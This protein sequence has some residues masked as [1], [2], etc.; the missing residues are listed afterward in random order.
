MKFIKEKKIINKDVKVDLFSVIFSSALFTG[1]I[2]KASGTFGS[3]FGLIFL[4]FPFFLNYNIIIPSI[5]I[6][7]FLGIITS[8]KMVK[9]YGDD[10]SVVVIDEVAGMW[11][12][13][14]ILR[15]FV[16]SELIGIIPLA[17]AFV[18]FRFFDVF[19]IFPA[20]FFDK[21]KSGF[22]IMMDDVIAGIYAGIAS[23]I[24]YLL[25]EKFI[26]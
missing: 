13:V 19:K 7:F 16:Q 20:T 22:G 11:V 1:F 9:K 8:N 6:V 23:G 5:I 17:I 4:F 18:S 26:L 25:L 3:L 15:L 14:L 24:I 21:V 2:P 12:T 10:P